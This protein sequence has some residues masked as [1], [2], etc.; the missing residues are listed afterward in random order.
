MGIFLHF[1]ADVVNILEFENLELE[2]LKTPTHEIE[3][4]LCVV[5][6]DRA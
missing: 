1:Q 2:Y 4:G 3:M 5:R 6:M